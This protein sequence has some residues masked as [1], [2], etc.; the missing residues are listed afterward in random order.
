VAGLAP[1]PAGAQVLTLE[2]LTDEQLGR[3][4]KVALEK[5]STIPLPAAL[6]AVLRFSPAQVAPLVRQVSFQG[7]DGVKHGFAKLNDDSGY[8]LF[9]RAPGGLS[10]FHVDKAFKLLAAAHDFAGDRFIALAEKEGLDALNGEVVA[11]SRVLSPRGVSMPA[12]GTR[13]RPPAG[14]PP[15]AV[16]APPQA[17][18]QAPA[19]AP[20]PGQ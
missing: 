19:A 15:P 11:W 18:P 6:V 20:A 7:D 8:F 9:R 3:L 12:P 1:G 5:G 17:P 16:P 13:P 4:Q 10:A 14:S 2:R